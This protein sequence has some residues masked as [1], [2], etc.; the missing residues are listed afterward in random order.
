MIKS[1]L[2]LSLSLLAADSN[3]GLAAKNSGVQDLV[4]VDDYAMSVRCYIVPSK[5]HRDGWGNIVWG[6]PASL[7]CVKVDF[8]AEK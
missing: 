7:F 3:A 1:A 6:I 4:V 2:L 5:T 8:K